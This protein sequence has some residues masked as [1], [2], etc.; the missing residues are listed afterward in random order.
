VIKKLPLENLQL[1]NF[2]TPTPKIAA[3]LRFCRAPKNV[4]ATSQA[5]TIKI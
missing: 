5:Q 2:K 4:L 3:S 1:E